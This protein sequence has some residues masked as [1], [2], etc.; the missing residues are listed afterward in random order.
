M[1]LQIDRLGIDYLDRRAALIDAVTLDQLRALA[2]RLLDP[3]PSSASS[4]SATRPA[5]N[6]PARRAKRRTEFSPPPPTPSAPRG[7]LHKKVG[8]SG[9]RPEAAS[10]EPIFQRPVRMGSGL[11]AAR[12]PGMTGLFVVFVQSPEGGEGGGTHQIDRSARNAYKLATLF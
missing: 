12:R 3:G 9:A 4:W 10:P 11:A 7:A 8:H 5:S 1:Q 6:Q 2:R